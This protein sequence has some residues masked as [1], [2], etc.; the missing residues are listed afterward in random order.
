MPKRKE[1]EVR[2]PKA[3]STGTQREAFSCTWSMAEERE[4][5]EEASKPDSFFHQA[6]LAE[7]DD[8]CL[9]FACP[10]AWDW[11]SCFW[12]STADLCWLNSLKNPTLEEKPRPVIL[13]NE[14]STLW[15]GGS[16][17]AIPS[18]FIFPFPF[19]SETI[20][21]QSDRW[22]SLWPAAAFWSQHLPPMLIYFWGCDGNNKNR[23]YIKMIGC[24]SAV[25]NRITRCN[26]RNTRIR[27]SRCDSGA[28][29]RKQKH[30]FRRTQGDD[31]RDVSRKGHDKGAA[32]ELEATVHHPATAD[33]RRFPASTGEGARAVRSGQ[34]VLGNRGGAPANALP[35][36]ARPRRRDRG[37]N[38][39]ACWREWVAMAPI[40]LVTPYRIASRSISS[41]SPHRARRIP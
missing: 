20:G 5:A 34:A 23:S 28:M 35:G 9:V 1:Y 21:N 7:R 27:S 24:M 3:V 14:S 22:R 6:N 12:C 11:L 31:E 2:Q 40:G 33:T 29:V 8:S 39:W 26:N 15:N 30:A 32:L 25:I 41:D 18:F 19:T 4:E 17:P 36:P 13:R 10:R 16:L 37:T 38:P